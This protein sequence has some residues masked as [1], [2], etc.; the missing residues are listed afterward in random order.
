MDGKGHSD[1]AL[2][3]NEEHVIGNQR[4]NNPSNQVAKNLTELFVPWCFAEGR[5]CK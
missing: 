5:T 3:R 2:D 1:E 4:K